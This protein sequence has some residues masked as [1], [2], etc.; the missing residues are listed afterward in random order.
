MR[1]NLGKTQGMRPMAQNA[2]H[3][4][5]MVYWI[6]MAGVGIRVFAAFNT[7]V[8]NP[9]GMLYIQQA[10]AIYHGD[11]QLLRS[12]LSFVSSYP[13]LI[14]A[15]HWVV[16]SWIDA[17]RAISVLFGSLTLI[18]LYFLLRRFT[19]ER[20]TCLVV[21]LYAFMP[22][23]V[24]GSADLVR[25]PVCWF[26]LVS[27]LYLFVRQLEIRA[28]SWQRFFYLA[29]SYL[30]FLMAGWARP[31][32]F[33]FLIFSCFYTFLYS[34]FS[35]EKRYILVAV[36]SLLLL[37]LFS[38]AG[39]QIFDPSFSSY[40]ENASAKVSASL[41]QYR[42]LRH[43]LEVLT[44]NLDRGVLGSFLSKAKS[45]IWLIDLGVLISGSLA[46]IFYP[47]FLFFVI[48][49]FGLWARLRKDP[50]VTYLLTLVL[51]GYILLFFHVL[52]IWYLEHRFL[53]IA[54]LPGSILAAFGIEKATRF[55]QARMGWK[56]SAAVMVICLYIAGFGLG[57]NIK[58]REEDKAVYRQIAE[59]VYKL[60]ETSHGFVPVLTGDSSS[61]K[62][63]PF[64]VNLH[65]PVGFCP[66]YVAPSIKNNEELIQYVKDNNVKYFLW[67]G[68]NWSKTRVNIHS[69]HFRQLF[70]ELNRWDAKEVGGLILFY[71]N[72]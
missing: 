26:F 39:I 7:Y 14:A 25:D 2:N 30:L 11:W 17:A 1:T 31:E 15:A 51:L 19:D 41:E 45:L 24:G 50:R 28:I 55:F 68:K 18:P 54:V 57:K 20:T 61:L 3:S 23:L 35:E 69:D 38:T 5:R 6:I 66:L 71:R 27:G 56:A 49:L 52:Q 67:D 34:L 13:F 9:D 63:V 40:S 59:Y 32:A 33:M 12:C 21:L 44:D 29:A 43:Q 46:G 60:E 16:P 65:L 64:Y 22:F 42:N 36:S 70:K 62:L 4:I 48:G 47:Y 37:G 58:K 10:K 72:Q 53:H 8:T